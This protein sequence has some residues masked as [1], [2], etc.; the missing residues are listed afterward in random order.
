LEL[1]I[2]FGNGEYLHRSS[3]AFPEKDF[4]GLEIAWASIKRALRRL[5][6]PPR[7]NVRLMRLPAAQALKWFLAPESLS[8][9]RALF[10]VP[11]PKERH[12]KKR[13]FSR[14]F[15]DLAASRLSPSGIFHMVTDEPSLAEWTLSESGQSAL[16]LELTQKEASLDTKYERKWLSGGQE[17]FYHLVGQKRAHPPILSPGPVSMQPRFSESLDPKSYAPLG[18]NGHTTVIFGDFLY[19]SLKEEGLLETKV[20]EDG[21]IQEFHLRVKRLPDGPWK[22]FPALCS[23]IFPTE[24]VQLAMDLAAGIGGGPP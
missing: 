6:Q 23:Q 16:S 12:L 8:A 2:G 9:I 19:D 5:G 4:I 14:D 21:L 17:G 15:L 13:L 11:W 10:P 24:G 22:I 3:L 7:D 20:V 1:E 18:R